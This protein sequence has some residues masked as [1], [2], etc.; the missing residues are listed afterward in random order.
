MDDLQVVGSTTASQARESMDGSSFSPT[1][2]VAT[3][4][5]V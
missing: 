2:S 4:A 5:T 3:G 1:T